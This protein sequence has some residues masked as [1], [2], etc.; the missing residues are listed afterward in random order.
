M[1]RFYMDKS[2]YTEFMEATYQ[3]VMKE[4]SLKGIV[5]GLQVHEIDHYFKTLSYAISDP[6]QVYR[7]YLLSMLH[8]VTVAS[9]K[10]RLDSD[11]NAIMLLPIVASFLG[12]ENN[13]WVIPKVYK[14]DYI[15]VRIQVDRVL[16]S[17][18]MQGRMPSTEGLYRTL[19]VVHMAY[20]L[21]IQQLSSVSNGSVF[22][23]HLCEMVQ[24]LEPK[25]LLEFYGILIDTYDN[26]FIYAQV[27][28][29]EWKMLKGLQNVEDYYFTAVT[30]A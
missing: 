21:Y 25:E 22:E 10:M 24:S 4:L 5:D 29:D 11:K 1:G 26:Q 16:C 14:K 9:L 12:R 13:Y 8:H 27:S 23:F 15:F 17:D 18:E 2:R 19:E 6:Y 20:E 7:K 28:Y 3:R 30:Y